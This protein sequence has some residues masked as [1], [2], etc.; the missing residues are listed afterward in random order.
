MVGIDILDIDRLDTS[1]KF[2]EKIAFEEEIA[3]IEKSQCQSLQK[4]RL[5]ALFC[6]KEAVMKALEMGKDSG[7]SFKDIKLCHAENGK[8]YVELF[9]RA[10]EKFE[11]QWSGKHI[12]IS[13]SH[14]PCYA[15]AIA[16]IL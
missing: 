9:G 7:V 15:T 12:E 8:P 14:T 16:V 5:G 10:K 3:Y 1:E 13:L 2:K 6:V 4:Q 11:K